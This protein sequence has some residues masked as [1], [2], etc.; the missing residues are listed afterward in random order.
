MLGIDYFKR[1]NATYDHLT[2]EPIVITVSIGLCSLS[3]LPDSHSDDLIG[4]ADRAFYAAKAAGR[5]RVEV[6]SKAPSHEPI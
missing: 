6:F 5:N 4:A 2:G 1:V 3:Q